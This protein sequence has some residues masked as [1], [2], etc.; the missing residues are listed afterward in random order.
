MSESRSIARRAGFSLLATGL[1]LAVAMVLAEAILR[2][3]G[4]PHTGTPYPNEP[5]MLEP[6]AVRGWRNKPGI[7][8]YPAYR[9]GDTPILMTILRDGRRRSIDAARSSGPKIVLVGGSFVQGWAVSDDDTFAWELQQHFSG[10]E[11][12]NFGNAGYGTYQSLLLLEEILPRLGDV[13][14]VVYGYFDHHDIRNVG[15]SAWLASLSRNRRRGHVQV[16][17]V[18]MNDD[19]LRRF[20]PASYAGLP[21]YE[22]SALMAFLDDFLIPIRDR[23]LV[24]T[25][26]PVTNSL[27]IQLRELTARHSARFA[28][29]MLSAAPTRRASLKAYAQEQNLHMFDCHVERTTEYR[30]PGERHP[31]AKLHTLW[32][33]CL[34]PPIERLLSDSSNQG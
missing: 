6:H 13:S 14:L 31:N 8:R 18:R 19:E 20:P 3:M 34:V 24:P 27:L 25:G 30:V 17:F 26:A 1:G 12:V 23:P 4:Y 22:R 32:A 28:I 11:I 29:A 15:T 7:Y 9:S 5:T 10:F 21:L 16:P 2:M 33:D